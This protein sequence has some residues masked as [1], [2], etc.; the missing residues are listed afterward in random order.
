[1]QD[2]CKELSYIFNRNLIFDNLH[3]SYI[4]HFVVSLLDIQE[5]NGNRAL[6]CGSGEDAWETA[7]ISKESSRRVNYPMIKNWDSEEK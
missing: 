4:Y 7:T 5:C 2:F 3:L 6:G 1:M